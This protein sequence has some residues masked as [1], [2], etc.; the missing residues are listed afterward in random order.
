MMKQLWGLSFLLLWLV[1]CGQ[2]AAPAPTDV[3]TGVSDIQIAVVTSDLAVGQP[4]LPFIL[5]SGPQRVADVQRVTLT[6]LDLSQETPTPGWTGEATNFSDYAVPYWVAYPELPHAG[7]WGLAADIILADGTTTR[8][9]FAIEA[10]AES[11]APDVGDRPPASQN[12]TLETEPDIEKLTSDWEPEPA[13]YQM[14]IA[15]AVQSGQPT[16]V[17]FATPAFCQT[18]FCAPVV[19]SVKE[20]Y[21]TH[22]DEANFIHIEV[23]KQFNPELVLADEMTE[24]GF[25]TEPWT[26]VLDHEGKVAGRFGGPVSP[27]ELTAALEALLP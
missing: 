26:Y 13:L 4:R 23:Y 22:D 15:E 25:T 7:F 10:A 20:V 18:Q 24:W 19:N 9:Q 5:Y 6:A 1:G 3:P 8:A 17:T 12:R 2:A 14:T 21:E 16:I 11:Q 27:R